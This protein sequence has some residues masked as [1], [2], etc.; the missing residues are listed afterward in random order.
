MHAG[1]LGWHLLKNSTFIFA[2]SVMLGLALPGAAQET[3]PLVTP[4]LML[5]MA[6]SLCGV[7]LGARGAFRED[8]RGA[9][10]AA[11]VN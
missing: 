6:F 1:E 7:D 4:A 5:M 10:L 11:A 8:A 2:L 9:L 3:Q